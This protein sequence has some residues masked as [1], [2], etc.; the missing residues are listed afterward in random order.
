[1][2]IY[3]HKDVEEYMK[4]DWIL[5]QLRQYERAGEKEIRT[6]RWLLEMENKRTIYA[7]VY[8]DFL[9]ND[10]KEQKSVLDVGGGINA[11]TKL[12]AANSSYTLIDF[13][14]H[15]G[16]NYLGLHSE[17]ECYCGSWYDYEIE[18]DYDIVIANDLFPDVDQRMEIFLDKFLPHCRELRLVITFYNAPQFYETKRM[19][20][21]EIL[22]FL[23]WDGEITGLK[24]KKYLSRMEDTNEEEL[25]DL[26]N[27]DE[28]VFWNGR[29]V[30][31]VKLRGDR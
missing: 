31:Y 25:F 8:G 6:H 2:K 14:A 17:L 1:M 16:E 15:G 5:D 7:D 18:K 19:D 21:S 22:T 27:A 26:K 12:L 3:T 11:L 10:M 24:L 9:Q 13:L 23:S 30:A 29:Q 20:D 28:S 4:N